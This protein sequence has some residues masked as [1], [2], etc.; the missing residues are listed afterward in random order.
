MQE[1]PRV[2]YFLL[3]TLLNCCCSLSEIFCN[4]YSP[5]V[6]SLHDGV[7][8]DDA[9]TTYMD[10]FE[11]KDPMDT[12]AGK[13]PVANVVKLDEQGLL[14]SQHGASSVFILYLILFLCCITLTQKCHVFH[15]SYFNTHTHN[16]PRSMS[17][18]ALLLWS[19]RWPISRNGRPRRQ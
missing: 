4:T 10:L 8:V 7:S 15:S 17:N 16:R 5:A 9:R 12:T 2:L 14:H 1:L 3:Q 11:V 19:L 18:P 6:L 13:C